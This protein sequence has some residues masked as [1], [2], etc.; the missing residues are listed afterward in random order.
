MYSVYISH[1]HCIGEPAI[2]YFSARATLFHGVTPTYTLSLLAD[3]NVFRSLCPLKIIRNQFS[4]L[5]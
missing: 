2:V 5:I 1:I 3:L 4:E